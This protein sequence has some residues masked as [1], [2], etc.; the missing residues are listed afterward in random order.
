MNVSFETIQLYLSEFEIEK[1]P[2]TKDFVL[3]KDGPFS[4]IAFLT[5]IFLF[6]QFIGPY[7]MKTKSGFDLRPLMVVMNGL[8]FG[9]SV[10][11]VLVNSFITNFGFR[12]FDAPRDVFW[13]EIEIRLVFCFLVYKIFIMFRFVVAVLRKKD[14]KITI[15]EKL[16][17]AVQ[18]LITYVGLILFPCGMFTFIGITDMIVESVITGINVIQAVNCGIKIN[19]KLI[20]AV[21]ILRFLHFSSTVISTYGLLKLSQGPLFLKT[22]LLCYGVTG[23]LYMI[24][25]NLF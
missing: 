18:A 10:A 22:L 17:P 5:S 20:K 15:I 21:K 1:D 7:V 9:S 6:I 16:L 19:P 3:I 23:S 24:K 11:G 14:E 13:D 4:L 12:D 2:R 25:T 8:L